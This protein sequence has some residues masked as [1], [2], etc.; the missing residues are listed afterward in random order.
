MRRFSYLLLI[1]LS[2]SLLIAPTLNA[3]EIEDAESK[4]HSKSAA[5]HWLVGAYE[6]PGFKVVQSTLPVL[7]IYSYLLISDGEALVVDPVRDI[8]FYLE[9]AKKEN[10][11][12]KGVYLSH[13]HADF[14]A[15][16]T[17]V[18]AELD[19]PIYQSHKSGAKYPHEPV[20]EKSILRIGDAVIKFLDTPGHT[21]DGMCAVVYNKDDLKSPELLFTG[22]VLFVG[23]VGRPDLM[24]G[25]ISASWLASAMYDS[26]TNKLSKLPDDVMIFP[27]HGAGSLCGANLSDEPKSTLG[28]EKKNN[29]YL[30]VKSEAAFVAKVLQG[31]PDA[32]QYFSHNAKI[33][34][35]GPEKVLWDKPLKPEIKP[36]KELMDPKN[37]YVVDLR[38]AK[39]YAEGHIPNSVNIAARGRLETW[40]GSMVPWGAK[41]VLVGDKPLL[42]EA[43]FR[44]NRVGYQGDVI[45]M[46]SWKEA[47]MPVREGDP[48]EPKTLYSLMKENEQPLIVD[49]RLPKEWI[50][51]RIGEVLNLPLNDLVPLSTLLDPTEPVVV[52]CNSAYRSSMAAGILEREGFKHPRNLMGGSEAWR[53]AGYP[54]KEGF[55]DPEYAAR[56]VTPK[57]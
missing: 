23:S 37:Y 39:A 11:T 8:S 53:E 49:V 6:F 45:T 4:T 48:I 55:T 50:T 56:R 29:P 20:D 17:E 57:K 52:V 9:Q 44:L 15:G 24:E 18:V 19:V 16:H 10:V 51:L 22:D 46:E 14:I 7:S 1:I 12:I 2:I 26:W 36:S 3:A 41:L 42:K 35:K 21:P 38:D 34:R 43:L 13:S 54:V 28:E 32:P 25:Q 5:D 27:A 33:N 30:K 47:G 31:L 40:V